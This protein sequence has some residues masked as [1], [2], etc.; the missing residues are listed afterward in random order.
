[1]PIRATLKHP[2]ILQEEHVS[3]FYMQAY[4]D[5]SFVLTFF[6]K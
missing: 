6:I 3:S 1:M 5:Y 4:I 2:H